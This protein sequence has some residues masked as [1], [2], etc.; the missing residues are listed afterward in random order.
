LAVSSADA[1]SAVNEIISR[2]MAKKQQMRWTQKGAHHLLQVR[3]KT[4]NNELIYSFER[5]YPKMA[6]NKNE[7][8]P[9]AA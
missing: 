6:A 3:T 9:L 2:R 5:W 8:L 4:L 1:E 7:N